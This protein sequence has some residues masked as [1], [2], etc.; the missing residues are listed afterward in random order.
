MSFSYSSMKNVNKKVYKFRTTL[1]FGIGI[2]LL[3]PIVF[4]FF[5]VESKYLLVLKN[6]HS[7]HHVK[8]Q[9]KY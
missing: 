3:F 8:N 2:Y 9:R 7:Q 5:I 1:K 4:L 6:I